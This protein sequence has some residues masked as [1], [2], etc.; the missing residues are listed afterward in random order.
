MRWIVI[1]RYTIPVIT[2][3]IRASETNRVAALIVTPLLLRGTVSYFFRR[4]VRDLR[5]T[6]AISGIPLPV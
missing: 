5:R 6:R 1:N 3:A 2:S 4:G